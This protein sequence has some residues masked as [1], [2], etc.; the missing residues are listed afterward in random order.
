MR[1]ENSPEE[2]D[3][4]LT[5]ACLAKTG[6]DLEGI[7]KVQITVRSKRGVLEDDVILTENEILLYDN[8]EDPWN[9]QDITLYFSDESGSLLLTEKR[10]V[11]MMPAEELPQ[12]AMELLLSVPQSGGMLS[13]LP[14]GTGIL[15]ISV[16]NGI[17]SVDFNADFYSNR[18]DHEQAEQLAILSV[19]NTLCGLDGINAVQIYSQGTKLDSYG[20]MDLSKPWMMD[21]M[22]IGPIRSELGEFAGTLYLPGETDGLLHRLTVR[23]RTRGG[24]TREEALLLALFSRAAQNGLLAPMAGLPNPLS[25]STSNQV[26]TVVL[27][28][29][30]LPTDPSA[31]ELVIRS[32][33]ASLC[34]LP[35]IKSVKILDGSGNAP[36]EALTP[37][38]E[39]FC[40][41]PGEIS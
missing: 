2:F 16:E 21:S 1:N 35:R 15:D 8:G 14:P 32:I 6:L 37:A 30:S 10:T 19:V 31:R 9:T 34:T 3:H 13:A 7:N 18:P 17:C 27:A 36:G 4:S 39:W 11:P 20:H 38:A 28:E 29:N 40:V 33:T 24:A 23:A 25:V 5:Y 26:C 12:Y 41:P 22:P